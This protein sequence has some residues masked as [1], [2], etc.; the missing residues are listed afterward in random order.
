MAIRIVRTKHFDKAEKKYLSKLSKP[1][2]EE[3]AGNLRNFT[4][5]EPSAVLSQL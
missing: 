4:A 1:Q 5:A 3:Y 2:K